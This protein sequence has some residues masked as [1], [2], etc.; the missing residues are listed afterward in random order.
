MRSLEAHA[1]VF[2]HEYAVGNGAVKVHVEVQRP[3]KALDEGDRAHARRERS[4][5]SGASALVG[6]DRAQREVERA[7]EE[8]WVAGEQE[9]RPARQRQ[10]PLAHRHGGALDPRDEP[11][12]RACGGWCTKGRSRAPCTRTRPAARRRTRR[13]APARTRAR[14]CRRRGSAR[15]RPRRTGA[16]SRPPR[17]APPP[18]RGRSSS[19]RTV[20]C[21]SVR[22]GSRRR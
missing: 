18:R 17:H 16:G 21:R 3:A 11:Q 22:S 6:E 10:D 2:L 12:C 4:G 15:T 19:A 13:S 5:A 7:R 9:A 1:S 20:V 14:G 8:L